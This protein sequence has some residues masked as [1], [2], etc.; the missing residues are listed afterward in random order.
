MTIFVIRS[1]NAKKWS[2]H[3]IYL[4]K[5]IFLNVTQNYQGKNKTKNRC[6]TKTNSS[7]TTKLL[8]RKHKSFP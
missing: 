3:Y 1:Y 5:I 2:G 8:I 7:K 4:S 6:T